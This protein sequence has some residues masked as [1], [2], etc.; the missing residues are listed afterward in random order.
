MQTDMEA[1]PLL[2]RAHSSSEIE[3]SQSNSVGMSTSNMEPLPS[4]PDPAKI[5]MLSSAEV[6]P[7]YTPL[8]SIDMRDLEQPNS[9]REFRKMPSHLRYSSAL[10]SA[11]TKALATFRSKDS[12][13]PSTG[14]PIVSFTHPPPHP[15]AAVVGHASHLVRAPQLASSLS[16]SRFVSGSKTRLDRLRY[17]RR[18]GGGRWMGRLSV[19]CTCNTFSMRQ[20]FQHFLD[21]KEWGAKRFSRDV[22]HV[23]RQVTDNVAHEDSVFIAAA[24]DHV[25]GSAEIFFFSYGVLACWGLSEAGEFEILETIKPFENGR[26]EDELEHETYDYTYFE[27]PPIP[28]PYD[29]VT[30]SAPPNSNDLPQTLRIEHDLFLVSSLLPPDDLLLLKLACSHG[31]AQS[32]KLS[33]FESAVRGIFNRVE[34]YPIQLANTG[35]LTI[36]DRELLKLGGELYTY[37]SYINLNTDVLET[38][39]WFWDNPNLEPIYKNVSKYLDVQPRVNVLNKRLGVIIDMFQLFRAER[40]MSYGHRLEWIV[41][42]LIVIEVVLDL[43]EIFL[44]FV[45]GEKI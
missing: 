12:G 25:C 39:D 22:V 11:A 5:F 44:M 18:E 21:M 9:A 30:G 27:S 33:S 14:G 40:H 13:I 28:A 8:A 31:A 26:F 2:H 16:S 23:R 3:L 37:S 34:D 32:V 45:V 6:I 4:E 10:T 19:F 7:T 36:S 20:L 41:I 35:K 17:D 42:W 29:L 38:P 15:H 24:E 1:Q 43:F